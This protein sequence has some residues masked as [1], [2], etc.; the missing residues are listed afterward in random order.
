MLSRYCV[1][2]TKGGRIGYADAALGVVALGISLGSLWFPFG[3]DQGLFYYVG[4]EWL[5]RSAI[6]YRDVW[7]H[8]PPLI[9]AV[10]ALAIFV[11]G[12]GMRSI[13][14]VELL[15]M[16]VV[17]WLAAGVASL[18]SPKRSGMWGAGWL[19]ASL[20]YQGCLLYWDTAQCEI[21]CGAFALASVYAA[22]ALRRPGGAAFVAGVLGAIALWFKPPAIFMVAVGAAVVLRRSWKHPEAGK[23]AQR[24]GR[25][26]AWYVLGV[27]AASAPILLYFAGHGA[28]DEMADIVVGANAY[29]VEHEQPSPAARASRLKLAFFHTYGPLLLVPV[30]GAALA[31]LWGWRARR[32]ALVA[33]YGLCLAL[34]IAAAATGLVQLKMYT[35]HFGAIAVA[36]GALGAAGYRDLGAALA[37]RWT[38]ARA[39]LGTTATFALVAL[40]LF[41]LTPSSTSWRN[42]SLATAVYALGGSSRHDYARVFDLPQQSYTY[43]EG[44]QVGLWLRRHARDGDTLAVRHF[45][46]QIYA[47]SELHH[48]GRFFWTIFLTDWR[49]AYA[50]E[51]WRNEDEAVFQNSPPRFVVA[52][53]RPPD[54]IDGCFWFSQRGY[55]VV[56][57][58]KK[59]CI[60][61]LSTVAG[62][63]SL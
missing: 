36:L 29:Y 47:I 31:T 49:R 11:F 28:L 42:A 56:E 50:R 5:E 46:P 60:L 17:G 62:L 43:A 14:L 45:E 37:R 33:R 24:T 35:Y 44:E 58:F 3:R 20:G 23:R 52:L 51:R 15:L 30:A 59:F 57:R 48:T 6:P 18:E 10:H 41:A 13:R 7:D 38:G 32:A 22:L 16:P 39:A 1:I 54:P 25:A 19:A 40:T 34:T 53:N 12:E 4:R 61:E 8:K 9:Y 21:W 26:V 63:A 2:T 55:R 27:S